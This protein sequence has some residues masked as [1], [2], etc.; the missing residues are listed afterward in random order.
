TV[1]TTFLLA[2]ELWGRRVAWLAAIVLSCSH[3][4]IHFSRL[5]SNQIFDGL[6]TTLSLWLLVRALRS[7]RAIYF[8]LAGAVMGLGWYGYVGAR[9]VGIIAACYLAWRMVAEQRFR[10]AVAVGNRYGR[11]LVILL[12]AALIVVAPLL[13]HYVNHP[14]ELL[15]RARQVSI[16]SSGWLEREQGITG[17]S[18]ASLLLQ[19]FWKSISAFNYTLDP[20]FWYRSSIPVLDSVSGVLFVLGLLWTMGRCRRPNNGLL[21]I[22]FWLGL[23]LGW[24]MTENPP[25]SQRMIVLAPA[26][27]LLVGLGLN[28][29]LE[30][31]QQVFESS[32]NRLAGVL[33]FV[34]AVL[35]LRYYFLV[36]TP[37][38]VYGNP[39]AEV[40]TELGRYLVQQGDDYIVYFHAPPFM[41]W[42]FGTLAFMARSI[43]GVDVPPAG[44][45]EWPEP[46][47]S[48]GVRFVFLPERI[49]ELDTIRKRYPGG[50]ETSAYSSSDDR[51]LYVLY[52]V[53][54]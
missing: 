8:A 40:A 42:N 37:T 45:E 24:V 12:G 2:R 41:Y 14:H 28:W 3:F 10:P 53:D 30:L 19:Q 31:G 20:T 22:W 25:S 4:H 47:L 38:R 23:G 46:D 6:F 43:E 26:L 13:L 21:L 9:L 51:L 11:L 36:Y 7:R 16:L 52:Q 1:L 49:D 18:A 54:K 15:S 34:L 17:R 29:L 27:A 50:H 48:R 35:N 32:W 39:T 33:L 44:G 5:G